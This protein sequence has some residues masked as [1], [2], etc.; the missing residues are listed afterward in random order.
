MNFVYLVMSY[1]E[2][3]SYPFSNHVS[4]KAPTHIYGIYTT[5]RQ[6]TA[7]VADIYAREIMGTKFG[8]EYAVIKR[9]IEPEEVSE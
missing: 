8:T 3:S 1:P 4:D 5:M 6:A 9:R 2:D 7:V